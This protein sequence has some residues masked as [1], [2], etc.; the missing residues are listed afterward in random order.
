[1]REG[2]LRL[3]SSTSTNSAAGRLEIYLQGQWGTVCDDNFD[4][5]AATVACR[6]LGYSAA[7]REGSVGSLGYTFLYVHGKCMVCVCKQFQCKPMAGTNH[8]LS[9][10][11]QSTVS[12]VC[13]ISLVQLFSS[14]FICS[15]LVG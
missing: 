2:S 11:V 12:L 6:Q 4:F 1:M 7:L 15:Y 9:Q 8:K 14:E 13:H 5:T 3:V 10:D